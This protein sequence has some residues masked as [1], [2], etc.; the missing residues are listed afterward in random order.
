MTESF[1][2]PNARAISERPGSIERTPWITLKVAD[3]A[4]TTAA[5]TIAAVSFRP[6]Q[7]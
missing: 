7:R 1:E 4:T 5:A 2:T 3:G 6:S